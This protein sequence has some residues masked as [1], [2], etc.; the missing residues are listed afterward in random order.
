LAQINHQHNYDSEIQE[1]KK[2]LRYTLSVSGV[3]RT[4]NKYA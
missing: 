4:K 3:F 1:N 2:R